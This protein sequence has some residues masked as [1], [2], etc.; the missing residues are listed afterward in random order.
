MKLVPISE[1]DFPTWQEMRKALYPVK[2]D[3]YQRVEMAQRIASEDW[4]CQF[5]MN[6]SYEPIG[7]VELSFRNIVDSCLCSPVPYVEALYIKPEYRRK[8][9][10]RKI[11]AKLV[12]WCREEGY[13]ELATDTE[14]A[15]GQAQEFYRAIGFEETDRVVSFRRK[16]TK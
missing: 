15:N 14:L 1:K 13:S 7:L 12:R 3:E 16:I 5:L 4:H 2:S 11:M 9:L 10:A 8:G 6:E